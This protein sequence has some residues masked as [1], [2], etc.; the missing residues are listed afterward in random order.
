VTIELSYLIHCEKTLRLTNPEKAKELFYDALNQVQNN[1]KV[2]ISSDPVNYLE[3]NYMMQQNDNQK[4]GLIKTEGDISNQFGYHLGN[5]NKTKSND[6]SNIT[7]D[8]IN[9]ELMV[10]PTESSPNVEK[11]SR[12]RKKT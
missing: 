2:E 11:R 1:S 3:Y 6:I 4:E 10:N 7:S 8:V 9:N 5:G 12:K